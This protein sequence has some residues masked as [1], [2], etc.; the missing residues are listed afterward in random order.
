VDG[1]VYFLPFW[2]M[3]RHQRMAATSVPGRWSSFMRDLCSYI[4]LPCPLAV[5]E[6]SFVIA[7]LDKYQTE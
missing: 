4:K 7:T 3:L 6:K 1:F 2:A 5:H